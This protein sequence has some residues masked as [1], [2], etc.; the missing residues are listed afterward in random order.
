MALRGRDDD[1]AGRFGGAVEHH[2]LPVFGV[3]LYGI[4]RQQARLVADIGLL[5]K[6]LRGRKHQAGRRNRHPDQVPKLRHAWL[7]SLARST[8]VAGCGSPFAKSREPSKRRDRP[9]A[10]NPAI[11]LDCFDFRWLQLP[12]WQLWTGDAGKRR[13]LPFAGWLSLRR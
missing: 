9:M 7:S 5:R 1:G 6:A 8:N 2:L 11:S 4:I 3:Q 13:S 10:S 12:R